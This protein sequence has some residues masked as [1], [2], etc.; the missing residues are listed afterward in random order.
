M[1]T[2]ASSGIGR[3]GALAL[4][5]ATD[6][7]VVDGQS[8]MQQAEEV[9]HQIEAMGRRAV[10]VPAGAGDS[11]PADALTVWWLKPWTPWGR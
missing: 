10:A 4:A 9:A 1:V 7:I 11:K 5:E 2:G 6:D 3:A 8:Q